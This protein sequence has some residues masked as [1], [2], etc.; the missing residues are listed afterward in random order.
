MQSHPGNID[1]ISEE[2][3]SGP[4]SALLSAAASKSASS[5]PGHIVPLVKLPHLDN[6]APAN[7]A[8]PV[9]PA[10]AVPPAHDQNSIHFHSYVLVM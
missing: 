1:P 7:P 9:L 8:L 3:M 10:P 5:L 2:L 4:S 6:S